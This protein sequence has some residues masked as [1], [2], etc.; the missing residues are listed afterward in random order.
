MK[1]A[2]TLIELLVVVAIIGILAAVGTPVYQG[3]MA[4][5]K[6][7]ATKE[8]H[9]RVKN[10]MSAYAAQC[11]IND[12]KVQLRNSSGNLTSVSCD[13][14]YNF[15]LKFTEYFNSDG[16]KNPYDMSP[17]CY[18]TTNSSRVNGETHIG[19]VDGSYNMI[20]ISTKTGDDS[21]LYTLSLE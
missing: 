15:A 2:F 18:A 17:C 12:D 19:G 14:A 20:Y 8:N 10:M 11:S 7:N 3:F 9:E 5:A 13:S 4:T 6:I 21:L 1:K 16:W